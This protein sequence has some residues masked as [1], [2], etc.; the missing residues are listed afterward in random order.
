MCNFQTICH[1]L[2][3]V[4][5]ILNDVFAYVKDGSL[6]KEQNAFIMTSMSD[7]FPYLCGDDG[8]CQMNIS[9]LAK[10]SSNSQQ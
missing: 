3:I 9:R 5:M 4:I 1:L 2:E 6:S 8:A 10:L 7:I